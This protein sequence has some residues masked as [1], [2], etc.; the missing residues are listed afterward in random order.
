M[1]IRRPD[2]K[3]VPVMVDLI[4]E[5]AAKGLMLARSRHTVYQSLRDFVVAADEGRLIGVGALHII[6]EDMA[7]VRSLAVDPAYEGRGVG[8]RIVEVLLD[9]ARALGL[10]RVFALTY[11]QGFFERMGFH[12]VPKEELPHKI[13]GD[14]L[15]CP[16]FPNCD[17]VALIRDLATDTPIAQAEE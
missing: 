17:E 6:W 8:R 12:V 2:I 7:E 14:C 13:W 4:N 9:D 1:E 3:D 5:H 10:P 15:N 16:K 11:V